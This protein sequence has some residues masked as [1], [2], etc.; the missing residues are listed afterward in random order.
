MPGRMQVDQQLNRQALTNIRR[1]TLGSIPASIVISLWLQ[2]YVDTKLSMIAIATISISASGQFLGCGSFLRNESS[3]KLLLIHGL[4]AMSGTGWGLFALFGIPAAATDGGRM[5]IVVMVCGVLTTSV[6]S[7]SASPTTFV[8]YVTPLMICLV[9]GLGLAGGDR[10][11]FLGIIG[12]IVIIG[13]SF[14][15]GHVTTRSAVA[16]Q[17]QADDLAAQLADALRLTEHDS[18]HDPLTGAGNRR[19]F[20][21]LH[22][23]EV[24]LADT[25]VIC[26]DLD[27]FK[28]LNDQHGHRA[29]DELLVKATNRIRTLVRVDDKVIRTGGDEFVVILSSARDQAE[30]IAQRLVTQL[31]APY[32]LEV[33]TIAVSASVGLASGRNGE[34]LE[35]LQHR[36][37]EA[38]YQ[39]KSSGRG[40]L[41]VG[42]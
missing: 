6:A 40:V 36:A 19:L 32:E 10:Y 41:V 35:H 16:L 14:R 25:S 39:A 29:G 7:S 24:D 38:L 9:V 13:E 17:H 20:A 30:P 28:Q 34:T 26:I 15:N 8:V 11:L 4:V 3:M 12:F 31:A 2:P 18:L 5:R 33:G 21:R 1:I 22:G 27:H 37:D 23:S 42:L